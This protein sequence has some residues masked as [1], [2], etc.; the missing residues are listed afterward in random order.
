MNCN[1]HIT[2]LCGVAVFIGFGVVDSMH[3][4]V[5][6]FTDRTVFLT[7]TGTPSFT[8]DFQG[9]TSD[10][11]FRTA[12]LTI[13]GGVIQQEGL[14]AANFRNFVDV[15]PF[16]LTDNNGTNHASLFVDF[17]EGASPG[18]QVRLTFASPN[19][20]FGSDTSQGT[21]AEGAVLE[22]FNGAVLLGSQPVSNTASA[23]LGY[24]LTGGDVATSVRFRSASLTP[25]NTGE[26]FSIDNLLGVDAR[27]GLAVPEPVPF[28]MG[29]VSLLGL[30][31]G[32][33]FLR[34]RA[35]A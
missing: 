20:A 18:T 25:G 3:G 29:W 9:F 11:S 22:V 10:A 23:F 14:N 34:T 8:E 1:R 19:L 17:P 35:T 15:A 21:I 27:N 24:S 7:A 30:L 31:A 28:F 26:G 16:D 6:F 4:A 13:G 12:P 2:A 32:H 33:A 5:V